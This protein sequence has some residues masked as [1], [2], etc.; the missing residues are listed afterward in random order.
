MRIRF[1]GAAAVEEQ[2][3]AIIG[4]GVEFGLA[5]RRAEPERPAPRHRDDEFKKLLGRQLRTI[6]GAAGCTR[7]AVDH[8]GDLLDGFVPAALAGRDGGKLGEA[9][10]LGHQEP[11][12][13]QRRRRQNGAQD[14]PRQP[15]QNLIQVAALEERDVGRRP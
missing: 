11:M 7:L 4:P 5:H 13:R 14:E 3:D 8:G 10:P 2:R 12:E 9:S 15:P 1:P 6:D